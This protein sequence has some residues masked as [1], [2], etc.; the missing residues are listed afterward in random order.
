MT[1]SECTLNE[2]IQQYNFLHF[3]QEA[4]NSQ[5][6]T[7]RFLFDEIF[8]IDITSVADTDEEKLRNCTC[9]KIS[10]YKSYQCFYNE[11]TDKAN[12]YYY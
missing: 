6:R 8:G 3:S 10:F 9:G 11:N 5:A 1:E 4:N 2:V 7:G 12:N